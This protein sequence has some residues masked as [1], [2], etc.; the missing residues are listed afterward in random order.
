MK[1]Y[2]RPFSYNLSTHLNLGKARAT[3]TDTLRGDLHAFLRAE[4]ISGESPLIKPKPGC[5]SVV[6]PQTT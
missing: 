4:I 3:I 5:H 6:N 2:T 1:L